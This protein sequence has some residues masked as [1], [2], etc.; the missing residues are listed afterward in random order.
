MEEGVA[1]PQEELLTSKTGE[2]FFASQTYSAVAIDV[3]T[4]KVLG[5]YILQ[6]EQNLNAHKDVLHENLLQLLH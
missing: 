6:G 5:L 3:N 4:K 1:F 2:E